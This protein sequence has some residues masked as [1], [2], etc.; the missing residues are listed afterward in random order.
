MRKSLVLLVILGVAA[1][2]VSGKRQETKPQTLSGDAILRTIGDDRVA[3]LLDTDDDSRIDQGFLL[4]SDLP[5]SSTSAR[6]PRA[7]VEF[8]DGYVRIKHDSKVYDLYVA[9]YPEPPALKDAK[10]MT[11]F[12]G[13][14]LQHSTGGSGCTV[15]R[16][17]SD[18]GACFQYGKE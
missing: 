10:D 5:V 18:A 7:H 11:K 15:E 16:A 13:Y 17:M 2:P 14:A 9:G 6:C 1:A 3:V 8:T 4:S 12:I